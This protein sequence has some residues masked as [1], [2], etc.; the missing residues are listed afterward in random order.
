MKE[1]KR[2]LP[3]LKPCIAYIP[4]AIIFM[5]SLAGAQ[6]AL[7]LI[8][9]G[10]IDFGLSDFNAMKT[11]IKLGFIAAL[12]IFFSKFGQDFSLN[13]IAENMLFHLKNDV[14]SK[15]I[16]LPIRFHKDTSS[17][18]TLSRLTNDIMVLMNFMRH[19]MVD[20]VMQSAL[21]VASLGLLFHYNVRLLLIMSI[22]LPLV[23]VIIYFLG[24][25]T[26]K[27]TILSQK[28]LADTVSVLQEAIQGI[29]VIKLF[30]SETR[31]KKKYN[32]VNGIYLKKMVRIHQVTT[33]SIPII[34]VLGFSSLLIIFWFGGK[35]VINGKMST[36]DFMAFFLAAATASNPIRRLSGLHIMIQQASASANRI[37]EI[38]D[39]DNPILASQGSVV[40]NSIDGEV[41]FD[42]V[43]FAYDKEPV[44]SD[45]TLNVK[46][47]QV[48]AL[49]GPS[50][51]GKTTFV[52]LIPRL[53]DVTAG[54]LSIDN[55]PI[56]DYQVAPL[57]RHIAVVS[58]TNFLFSGSVRS[59]IAYGKP[60]ASEEEILNASKA[61]YAHDFICAM[62]QGY[63]TEIG[64][65]GVKLSGGQRQR[66]AIAR[67]LLT[68][69]RI[70]IL[71]EATS[72]LDSESE[73]Y[74]QNAIDNLIKNR[75]TFIAAHRLSTIMNADKI[76]V[77]NK[78][79]IDS[80]GTHSELIETSTLYKKL[81]TIQFASDGE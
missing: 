40:K 58:Q 78:G 28:L 39:R 7:S 12:I 9:K 49:V 59:N 72:A 63:D 20:I 56:K 65:R 48:V 41:H 43:S 35:D 68:N 19:G 27:V 34:E 81:Y 64:E 17:G 61:A 25:Y 55:I 30:A 1:L 51:S 73:K 80:I 50:G 13:F 26:K 29:E 14:F 22:V 53:Y 23:I 16:H 11:I 2:L 76:V 60:D 52:N 67:A 45:I 8:M 46:P 18:D 71:D 32:D 4:I 74:V 70:L 31:E 15:M 37:F 66:I 79:K 5:L 62:D 10:F 36:G 33:L 6:S 44:L 47:G 21:L 38:V 69:P 42:N 75:T 54:T 3:Y 57:R 77:M 24:K